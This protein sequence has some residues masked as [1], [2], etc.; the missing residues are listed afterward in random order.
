MASQIMGLDGR[1]TWNMFH[2]FEGETEKIVT[3]R[4]PNYINPKFKGCK[5]QFSQYFI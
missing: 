3:Q 5:V 1:T 2:K 4:D